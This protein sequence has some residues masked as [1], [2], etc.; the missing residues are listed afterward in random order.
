M[1]TLIHQLIETKRQQDL[2]EQSVLAIC[3]DISRFTQLRTGL[4]D[5]YTEGSNKFATYTMLVNTGLPDL[6]HHMFT[7]RSSVLVGRSRVKYEEA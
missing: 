4:I 6:E 5:I 1:P 2:F 7:D 3:S